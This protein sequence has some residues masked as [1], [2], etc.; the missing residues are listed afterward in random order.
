MYKKSAI[1]TFLF[2]LVV[3]QPALAF[4]SGSG[5]TVL[6]GSLSTSSNSTDFL[7]NGGSLSCS[8]STGKLIVDTTGG[9]LAWCNASTV[10]QSALGDDNGKALSGDDA[11]YFFSSGTLEPSFGGTGNQF[12]EFSGPSVSVKTFTL[13][14]SSS[15]LQVALSGGDVTT[16]SGGASASI[17]DEKVTESKLDA[18][19]APTD[20]YCLTYEGTSG[21]FQWQTCS[22]TTGVT[23]ISDDANSATTGSTVKLAGGAGITTTRATDT[24]TIST[25]SSEAGFLASGALSCGTSTAG[26]ALISDTAPL[27]YCDN[28][29]TP[30]LRYSA[31]GDTSGDAIKGDDAS[32][33]FTGAGALEATKGGTGNTSYTANTVYYAATTTP[34][35]LS[36]VPTPTPTA[37]PFYLTYNSSSAPSWTRIAV[38]NGLAA[39]GTAD[40]TTYLRG[41]GA[42]G[43][44]SS[45]SVYGVITT[46]SESLVSSGSATIYMSP[47]G[48]VSQT[49]S[50]AVR[51]VVPAGTWKNLRCTLSQSTATGVTTVKVATGGCVGSSLNISSVVT[52]S[53]LTAGN[54][55][56]DTT[57]SV[58]TDGSQCMN[59]VLVKTA[60]AASAWLS[61]TIER[62]ANS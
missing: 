55:Y 58:T 40:A 62:T 31:Y 20:E 30:V 1:S 53:M 7:T 3:A 60:L 44:L 59:F 16:T 19:T 6:N 52:A 14:N 35:A 29:T 38:P 26:K 54:V 10:Y 37:I 5:V 9:T 49:D 45:S 39:T 17:G 21:R 57:N 8:S 23:G 12:T 42:W 18:E 47:S 48:S 56:A 61:C 46:V 13:P 36:P 2:A 28:T 22:S 41:D 50:L 27:Q 33:F 51:T 24:R 4:K 32:G 25:A 11:S 43:T 15:T 34:S